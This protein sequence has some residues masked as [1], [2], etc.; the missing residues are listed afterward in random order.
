MKKWKHI[1]VSH[2]TVICFFVYSMTV[3]SLA[4]AQD[5][6]VSSVSSFDVSICGNITSA[7]NLTLT[8]PDLSSCEGC[9]AYSVGPSLKYRLYD[10]SG[11]ALVTR[12]LLL[13]EAAA[14]NLA[15]ELTVMQQTWMAQ[16]DR[17]LGHNTACM[18]RQYSILDSRYRSLQ[19]IYNAKEVENQRIIVAKNDQI[20]RLSKIPFWKTSEFGVVVGVV[21]GIGI[22]VGT[23]YALGQID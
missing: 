15:A 3:P 13:N 6:P 16:Y 7:P 17:I 20:D 14:A 11:K 22:T 12:G 10:D 18:Q 23:G 1:L 5:L 4:Y 9:F 21:L 8:L 2:I 19:I